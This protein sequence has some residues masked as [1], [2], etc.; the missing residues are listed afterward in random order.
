MPASANTPL[1]TSYDGSV[2]AG[3]ASGSSSYGGSGRS[4]SPA[5]TAPARSTSRCTGIPDDRSMA[6][7]GLFGKIVCTTT[8]LCWA[9]VAAMIAWPAA[10]STSCSA[11][12]SV[13]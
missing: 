7:V 4:C 13:E 6:A 11:P 5:S 9:D 12:G 3:A 2:I 8:G 10:S 1:A